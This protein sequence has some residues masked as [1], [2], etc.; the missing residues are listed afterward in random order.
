[1]RE[2]RRDLKTVLDKRLL[3]MEKDVAEI[4]AKLGLL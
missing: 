1:V 2:L 3:K 4:K